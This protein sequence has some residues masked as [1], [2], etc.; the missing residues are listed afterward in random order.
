VAKI[1]NN[2]RL[3]I[4]KPETMAGQPVV[5]LQSR[6][7]PEFGMDRHHAFDRGQGLLTAQ[8]DH[9][10]ARAQMGAI[11]HQQP[12]GLSG[13]G[14]INAGLVIREPGG[15]VGVHAHFALEGLASRLVTVEPSASPIQP[16]SGC[17]TWDSIG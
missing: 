17:L 9:L 13:N 8:A 11:L 10:I 1:I 7:H 15:A 16:G 5:R 12:E 4:G 2:F 14:G 6:I 3:G